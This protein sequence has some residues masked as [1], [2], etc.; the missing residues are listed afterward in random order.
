[1]QDEITRSIVGTLAIRIS[2]IELERVSG[3]STDNLDAYD[4]L[5]RGRALMARRERADNLKARSL[6]EQALKLDDRYA[7]A[8]SAL[9]WTYYTEATA[10]WVEFIADSLERA[11]QL[12]QRA[13]NI[14]HQL[15]DAHQLLGLV[16]L[17]RKDYR[18][19]KAQLDQAIELN[20]S[21]AYSYAAHGA[22]LM[23]MGRAEEAIRMLE[24][25]KRFDPLL[26]WEYLHN[27]GFAYFL[28][29]DYQE[30][31][32][33]L[34]PIAP[35]G[36]DH[37]AY[38]GLAASYA[39]LGRDAEAAEAAREVKRRWPFFDVQSFTDQWAEPEARNKV[40]EGLRRAGLR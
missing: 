9:G 7:A 3:K 28:S 4:Y 17:A 16:Y 34:E 18:R 38:A 6:F 21:D 12:G 26:H 33:V 15:S 10:G 19:A 39:L 35:R 22:V 2:R 11:E 40:A 13:L 36:S 31:V 23:W 25:A 24:L 14:D 20:P 27:L 5:L 8:Y 1:M 32:R 29:G 30:A 37:F